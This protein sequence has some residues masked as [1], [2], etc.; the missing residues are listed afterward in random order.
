MESSLVVTAVKKESKVVFCITVSKL[1]SHNTIEVSVDATIENKQKLTDFLDQKASGWLLA[2][3][4]VY[5]VQFSWVP[6]FD[7]SKIFAFNSQTGPVFCDFVRD[8]SQTT[9]LMDQLRAALP[10]FNAY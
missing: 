7:G 1:R 9:D 6:G 4:P 2:D 5:F 10:L 3:R 8:Q